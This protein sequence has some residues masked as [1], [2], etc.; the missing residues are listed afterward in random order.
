LRDAAEDQAVDTFVY[1][2]LREGSKSKLE[3]QVIGEP[4]KGAQPCGN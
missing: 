4:Q 1:M 3:A 2:H